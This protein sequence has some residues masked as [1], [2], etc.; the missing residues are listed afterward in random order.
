ADMNKADWSSASATIVGVLGIGVGWWWADSAA[1]I[2]V[3]V[4]IVRDGMT[5]LI[6]AIGDLTD[7]EARTVDGSE[8]HPLTL[9]V[10]ERALARPWIDRARA[11]VRDEGH[12]FHAELFLVPLAGQMPTMDQ[13][14]ELHE[15]LED[16]DWKMHDVVVVPVADLPPDQTFRST[17]RD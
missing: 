8:P 6:A 15:E 9:E 17:L 4:S 14:S 1:A 12:L 5:N 13:L 2:V 3:S 16:L 11:R 10:E 7:T